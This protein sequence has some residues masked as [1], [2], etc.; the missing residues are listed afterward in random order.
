MM[1]NP[2]S[3]PIFDIISSYGTTDNCAQILTKLSSI[4][5]NGQNG[6]ENSINMRA[7]V[8][9]VRAKKQKPV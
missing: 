3:Q 4:E 5:L 6:Q 8:Y 9:Q 2:V 7:P 1:F